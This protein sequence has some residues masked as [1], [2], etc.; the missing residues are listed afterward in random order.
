MQTRRSFLRTLRHTV[1][2]WD[3][4]VALGSAVL[5]GILLGRS[6]RPLEPSGTYA[7]AMIAGGL[8]AA[9]F[10]VVGLRWVSDRMKDSAYGELIR[11]D[12]KDEIEVSLPY[13]IVG[14]TAL[15]CAGLGI[16]GAILDGEFARLPLVA[17]WVASVFASIYTLLGL[18]G[19]AGMT[20][21]HQRQH[22]RLQ[23]TREE[24][25]RDLRRKAR[26]DGDTKP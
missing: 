8:A 22:A 26:G 14:T 24:I 20:I 9:T 13:W 3:F 21:W 17:F 10:A 15:A 19:L 6:A 25:G 18:V 1:N 2:A 11:A 4:W 7:A 16:L 5:A 12:D 23:A